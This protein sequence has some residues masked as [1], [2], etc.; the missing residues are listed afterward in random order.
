MA[1]W[2]AEAPRS[3][4]GSISDSIRLVSGSI[5]NP[6][7]ADALDVELS[8]SDTEITM[9][10]EGTELGN[11]PSA[12]VE[13]RRIDSISFEFIA[14]GDRLI[15]MPDDPAIFGDD[16]LVGGRAA[17][18]L[19]PRCNLLWVL[20]R[21]QPREDERTMHAALIIFTTRAAVHAYLGS[22]MVAG[23]TATP[24]FQ[25]LEIG[26]YNIL[27]DLSAITGS[28]RTSMAA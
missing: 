20:I 16:L 9:R 25:G 7:E 2:G 1:R 11:W 22:E 14:E 4:D 5:R 19:Q 13:I 12:A 3:E 15:L 18:A 26:H 17:T 24:A 27:N 23:L 21:G 10:A 28:P 6:D 8:I